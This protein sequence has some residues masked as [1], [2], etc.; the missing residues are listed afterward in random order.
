MA[1]MATYGDAEALDIVQEAM[2]KLVQKYGDRPGSEWK[3]LFFKILETRILDWHRKQQLKK[4]FFFWQHEAEDEDCGTA[5][6]KAIG[7]GPEDFAITEQLGEHLLGCVKGMPVKQQQ[8]FLLRCWEGLSVSDTA[9]AMG[10]NE[11]SVKTHYAR[12]MQKLRQEHESF[13]S[14]GILKGEF[15]KVES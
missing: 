6:T 10:I 14:Q 3:P 12:A 5:V 2:L 13:D 9:L 8:C 7:H 1:R 15:E 11:S 4:R